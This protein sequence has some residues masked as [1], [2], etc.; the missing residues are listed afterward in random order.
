MPF[1]PIND[2]N[3][4]MFPIGK[5]FSVEFGIMYS[6]RRLDLLYRFQTMLGGFV[7]LLTESTDS[8]RGKL[9]PDDSLASSDH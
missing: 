5:C 1:K 9:A 7:S 4:I 2:R 8:I 3:F 6:P